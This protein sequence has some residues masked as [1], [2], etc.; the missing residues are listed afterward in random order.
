MDNTKQRSELLL[1]K[2]AIETLAKKNV[3]VVGVG[4]VGGF[5]VEALARVGIGHLIL[6]DKD[7]VEITNVN[8]QLIATTQ[9]VGKV[10]VDLFQER[11]HANDPN[12]KVD[13]HHAFYDESMNELLDTY[14]IDF[15]IDCIDSMKSK[16]E[17]ISYCL[18]R[19]IPFLCSMGMAR[20]MDPSQLKVM[21][22]EKTSYDPMAKRLRTW[23][24]KNRIRQKIMVVASL[25]PPVDMKDKEVLPSTIFVPATAGLL[26]ASECVRNL[27]I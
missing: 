3:L 22:L 8:R 15:V 16:E 26:L 9:T 6:I 27:K 12:C 20:R 19:K 24:R 4:G 23:K 11:I 18:T 5:C 2:E 25:E 21:E 10:K 1:G 14:T 13:V 17:L 7:T